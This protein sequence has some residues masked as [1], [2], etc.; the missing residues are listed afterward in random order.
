M[1]NAVRFL[2]WS[3]FE[4]Q[5]PIGPHMQLFVLQ[6]RERPRQCQLAERRVLALFFLEA[7]C[8]L[9]AIYEQ[10]QPVSCAVKTRFVPVNMR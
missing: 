7:R 2:G 3:A 9:N 10:L 1:N 5:R 8:F 6:V 4:N